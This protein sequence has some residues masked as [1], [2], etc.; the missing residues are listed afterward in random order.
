MVGN[1]LASPLSDSDKLTCC[2]RLRGKDNLAT[3]IKHEPQL[4]QRPT[5]PPETYVVGDGSTAAE[6]TCTEAVRACKTSLKA[7]QARPC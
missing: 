6:V 2:G 7:L 3:F 4:D 1:L 5:E